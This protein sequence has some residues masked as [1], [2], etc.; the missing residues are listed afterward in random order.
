MRVWFWAVVAILWVGCGDDDGVADT[1]AVDSGVDA[2][3]DSSVDTATPDTGPPYPHDLPP[4]T[5]LGGD[6]RG[7][8]LVRAIIHVHSPLSHDACDDQENLEEA[9]GP[10][11][12]E[13][14]QHLRDALCSVHVDVAMLTDHSPYVN[15]VSFEDMLLIQPGDEAVMDDSGATIANRITCPDDGHEVLLTAGSENALMPVGLRHHPA[16]G[17]PATIGMA[18]DASGPEAVLA[19]Q[20]AGA[21]VLQNHPEDYTET[22][23]AAIGLDGVEIFNLH[24]TLDPRIRTLLE[25]EDADYIADLLDY[26]DRRNNPAPDLLWMTFF[27]T[28]PAYARRWDSLIA[29]GQR[30]VG[31]AGT[32]SHENSFP[33]LL[34]DGERMDGHRRMMRWFSNHLLVDGEI[35]PDSVHE[36]LA[37]GR[38]YVAYEAYGSPVGFD[39]FAE[40]TEASFDMGDE[41]PVGATLHVVRP[42]LPTDYPQ[43]PAPTITLRILQSDPDGAV[44]VAAGDTDEL[45]HVITE[46]GSYRAEVRIL[47]E[48]TRPFLDGRDHL[49][50]ERP[51]VQSNHIH[52]IAPP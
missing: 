49:I 13:C 3:V 50:R 22:E 40:T 25:I 45:T 7:R 30:V 36:A 1:G 19:F 44:E 15:E 10:E 38:L 27:E 16:M 21:L 12:I 43:D 52:A 2:I 29:D 5:E 34:K 41:V 17:D 26:V 42:T 31:T 14:L 32:D 28:S 4:T 20:A 23:L 37:T 51:W 6:R 24:A 39:F 33:D 9:T 46:A 48:H 18:Y 8:K 11:S 35:T 47:P